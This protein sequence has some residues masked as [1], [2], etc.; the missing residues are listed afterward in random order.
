MTS[1]RLS[2]PSPAK[3]AP[4]V[5]PLIPAVLFG[6]A[7]LVAVLPATASSLLLAAVGL[8]LAVFDPALAGPA[9]A[10]DSGTLRGPCGRCRWQPAIDGAD[11]LLALLLAAGAGGGPATHRPAAPAAAL[12]AAV[13]RLPA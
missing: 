9:A 5:A 8:A 6:V 3:L 7:L 12:A 2:I 13:R 1:Q 11:L 10:G 4:P